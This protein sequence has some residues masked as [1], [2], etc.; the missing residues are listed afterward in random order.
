MFEFELAHAFGFEFDLR[1]GFDPGIGF[2]TQIS[3]FNLDLALKPNLD[4]DLN[5]H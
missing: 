5:W 1:I 4:L 3:N 2:E